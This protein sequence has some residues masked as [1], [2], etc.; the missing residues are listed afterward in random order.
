MA[1]SAIKGVALKESDVSEETI[2]FTEK[3]GNLNTAVSLKIISLEM[4]LIAQR[5]S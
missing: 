5:Y 2:L 1:L 4:G 3:V